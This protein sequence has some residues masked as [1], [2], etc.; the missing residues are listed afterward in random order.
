[1]A[2]LDVSGDVIAAAPNHP[3]TLAEMQAKFPS[4]T[5]K[6]DNAPD[7]LQYKNWPKS[8]YYHRKISGDGSLI[9]HYSQIDSLPL[10]HTAKCKAIDRRTE[11]LIHGGFTHSSIQFSL[12]HHAQQN[13]A[14]Y[15]SVKATITWPLVMNSIDDM[16]SISLANQAAWDSFYSDAIARIKA[17][18][19]G[20][21]TLK[22]QCRAATTAAG[23]NAVTDTRT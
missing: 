18:V 13:L 10:V 5:T 3:A 20:G 4:I 6:I 21:T 2:F 9:T 8:G 1:V 17:I 16:N 12:S 23:I 11:E 19:D 14:H 7:G 15:E 22:E